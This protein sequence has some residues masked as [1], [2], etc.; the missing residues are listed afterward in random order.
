M[1]CL[2]SYSRLTHQ[3]ELEGGYA[4]RSEVVGVLKG[5]DCR[6]RI[7][8]KDRHIIRRT[9]NPCGARTSAVVQPG[10]NSS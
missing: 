1:N 5:L 7:F 8:K 3:F 10:Y 2:A 4:C 9:E 6:K